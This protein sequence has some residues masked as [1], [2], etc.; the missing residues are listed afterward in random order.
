VA[1]VT[2]ADVIQSNGVIHVIDA[3]LTPKSAM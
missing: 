3:V 1:N 2:I